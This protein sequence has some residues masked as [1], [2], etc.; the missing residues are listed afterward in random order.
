MLRHRAGAGGQLV[1][2]SEKETWCK[3]LSTVGWCYCADEPKTFLFQFSPI[4]SNLF[5]ESCSVQDLIFFSVVVVEN[6]AFFS[7][8]SAFL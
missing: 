7:V 2:R 5:G 6:I 8:L 1:L 3:R 4:A